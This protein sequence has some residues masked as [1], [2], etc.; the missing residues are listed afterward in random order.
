MWLLFDLEELT[1]P[2]SF[3]IALC[4]LPNRIPDYLG[5]DNEKS[6]CDLG[7]WGSFILLRASQI[8]VETM[9]SIV[10]K[11]VYHFF[12]RSTVF[13]YVLK[14]GIHCGWLTALSLQVI[15]LVA[16]IFAFA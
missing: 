2:P 5:L 6:I 1:N 13:W 12:L 10:L 14:A 15:I 3:R 11:L 7:C 4:E 9:K 16:L 8:S